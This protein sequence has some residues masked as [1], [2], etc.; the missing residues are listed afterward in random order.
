MNKQ[1]EDKMSMFYALLQV[2]SKH[3]AVWTGL[4][5]FKNAHDEFV[6]N[7]GSIEN[8]TQTQET[9]LKGVALD[10]RFKKEKMV[11]KTVEI[12]QCVFAYAVDK[13]D[14]VLQSKVDYSRSDLM[15]TRDALIAQTHSVCKRK[16]TAADVG[17]LRHEASLNG[18]D[19]L[20]TWVAHAV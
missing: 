15:Q 16:M 12:A 11:K 19:N 8:A 18:S 5:P 1:N 9:S 13:G 10:K 3:T 7:V 17:L 4:V 2:L 14:L 6:A 20:I